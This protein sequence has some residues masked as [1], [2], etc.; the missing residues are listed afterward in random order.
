MTYKYDKIVVM[1]R[2]LGKYNHINNPDY[3]I[4]RKVKYNFYLKFP[5]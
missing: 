2:K 3:I 1:L 5:R 4:I